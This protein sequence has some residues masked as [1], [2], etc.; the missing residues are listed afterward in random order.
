MS[1]NADTADER[2]TPRACMDP[3]AAW[4]SAT[5]NATTVND[6]RC[7][8]E[9]N[10]SFD[11]TLTT[12]R[13]VLEGEFGEMDTER[14]ARRRMNELCA[15]VRDRDDLRREVQDL[16]RQRLF[17]RVPEIGVDRATEPLRE[18]HN[19]RREVKYAKDWAWI[20]AQELDVIAKL[21]GAASGESAVDA[22]RRV[23]AEREDEY[24]YARQMG[25][26]AARVEALNRRAAAAEAAADA[27][28][29]RAMEPLRSLLAAAPTESTSE[30]ITRVLADLDS[31]RKLV[32]TL[33]HACL[34]CGEPV[35]DQPAT[36]RWCGECNPY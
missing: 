21:V 9:A 23:V 15:A 33:T 26:V 11:A 22:V 27:A 1:D 36:G 34:Q 12:V 18:V 32:A 4:V 29:D 7:V 19:L 30:A 14:I 2:A 35:T 31:A 17:G 25:E 8:V 16:R 24:H 13:R 6:V 10:V 28:V 5:G 20:R 3:I